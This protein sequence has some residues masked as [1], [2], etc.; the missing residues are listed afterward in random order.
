MDISRMLGVGVVMIIPSFVGSGAFWSLF[1]SWLAVIIWVVIM[2]IVY[3]GILFKLS[4]RP[5][6]TAH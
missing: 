2:A 3:G 4:S 1:G 5:Q 6:D